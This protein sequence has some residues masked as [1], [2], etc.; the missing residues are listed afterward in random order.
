M[1]VE[2]AI[3]PQVH[4]SSSLSAVLFGLEP[5]KTPG[6]ISARVTGGKEP[7][8]VMIPLPPAVARA[9]AEQCAALVE[10]LRR[11]R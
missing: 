8:I 9:I 6:Y 7:V 10:G 4:R 2:I 11:G 5:H 1:R 3:A